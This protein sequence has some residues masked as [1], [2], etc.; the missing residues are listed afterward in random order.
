MARSRLDKNRKA[1]HRGEYEKTAGGYEYRWREK[2][3]TDKQGKT[4]YKQRSV[5]ASTLEELR[6]ME[7]RVIRDSIDGLHPKQPM[8]VSR[9]VDE[10]FSTKRSLK[11]NTKQNYI[12]MFDHFVRNTE[13]G[14]MRAVDVRKTDA[15]KFFTHLVDTD[16]LSVSTCDT[17]MNCLLPAFERLVDDDVIRKN[18]FRGALTELKKEQKQK[19]SKARATGQQK[20]ESLTLAEQKRFLDVIKGGRFEPIFNVM[21]LTGMRAGEVTGLTESSLTDKPGMIH[22][23]Q[24]L[25]YYQGADGACKLAVNSTKTAAGN[26]YIPLNTKLEEMFDLQR[27]MNG[28]Q[29]SPVVDG[30]GDFIFMT[31]DGTLYRQDTLNRALKRIVRNAND[32]ATDGDVLLPMISTHKLRKTFACNC[33]RLNMPLSAIGLYLGH[34]D[35]AVTYNTYLQCTYDIAHDV[36]DTMFNALQ[37]AGMFQTAQGDET[38]EK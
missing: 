16:Q 1:L 21:L 22:V 10:Y 28:R 11:A 4:L 17:L 36:N 31:K 33:C 29:S 34:S 6:E 8:T 30:V 14:R 18:P 13:L 2:I 25:V 35:S 27:K 9:A 3:G 24:N 32:E 38:D 37:Q 15:M 20:V 12:Y 5:T 26:R 19:E 7:K 23:K